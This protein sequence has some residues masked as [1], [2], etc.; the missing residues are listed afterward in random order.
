MS[1][2]ATVLYD[3]ARDFVL[4]EYRPVTLATREDVEAFAFEIEVELSKLARKVDI[5]VNLGQLVVKPTAVVAYDEARQRMISLYALRA[6][7][8]SG[9]TLVRTRIL[10]SSAINGQT[11]NV[12][13]SLP[14]ALEALLSDRARGR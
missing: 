4:I 13:S 9:S 11:A 3:E 14:E 12:F 7:R 8:F 5:I 6:Y 2:Y 1:R 10:T